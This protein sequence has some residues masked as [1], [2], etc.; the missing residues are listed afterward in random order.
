MSNILI[1]KIFRKKTLFKS[2]AKSINNT[3]CLT[4]AILK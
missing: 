1:L 3:I 2:Q 4:K